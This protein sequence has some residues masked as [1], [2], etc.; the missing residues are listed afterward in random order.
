MRS[1]LFDEYQQ[2]RTHMNYM[3]ENVSLQ[4]SSEGACGIIKTLTALNGENPFMRSFALPQGQFSA[5]VLSHTEIWGNFWNGKTAREEL[6]Q[7]PEPECLQTFEV[8][9]SHGSSDDKA[10]INGI[11]TAGRLMQEK[12]TPNVKVQ[13]LPGE[14]HCSDYDHPLSDARLTHFQNMVE[15]LFPQDDNS[16]SE[17]EPPDYADYPKIMVRNFVGALKEKTPDKLEKA[18]R[19]LTA[20]MK[21]NQVRCPA[22]I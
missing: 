22:Q 4:Q 20:T 19:G 2:T 1:G 12:V 6:Q 18:I 10:D 8:V 21:V 13:V 3:D 7:A 15:A 16:I 9:L 11:P 17:P 14:N 5:L